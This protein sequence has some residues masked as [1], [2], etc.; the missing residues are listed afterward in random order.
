[1]ARFSNYPLHELRLL[2]FRCF[3]W[4]RYITISYSRGIRNSSDRVGEK[5]WK[6]LRMITQLRRI[7]EMLAR[8]ATTINVGLMRISD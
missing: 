1:M 6:L 2:E 3:V 5:K 8:Q 7:N 4:R